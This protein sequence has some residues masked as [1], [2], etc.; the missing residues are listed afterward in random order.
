MRY[1]ERYYADANLKFAM[2]PG[3]SF[4]DYIGMQVMVPVSATTGYDRVWV[5]AVQADPAGDVIT[6]LVGSP[7][8]GIYL[9]Y[10]QQVLS[11]SMTEN[12]TL[13]LYA[14]KDGELFVGQSVSDYTASGRNDIVKT[15]VDMVNYGAAVQITFNHNA[16]SLPNTNLG[17]YAD[18]GTTTTPVFEATNSKTG[19]GSVAVMK[20]SISMQAKV[21]IQLMFKTSDMNGKTFSATVNGAEA[22]VEY[23]PYSSYTICRVAVGA[24]QMR[25]TFTIAL[26]DAN[27][28]PVTQVYE[29]SV[30][31]YGKA[32]LTT[33]YRDVIIAMMRYGDSVA[34]YAAG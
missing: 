17:V 6:E 10:D 8:Y 11:W 27:S 7:Y 20:D 15:L 19:T 25:D 12:V 29:V 1:T 4:Q 24:S 18:K 32:Q 9:V 26:Y 22:P 34:A 13:T 21:E 28:N 3:L 5:E 30:E 16:S 2:A 23:T 33:A 14:E 31:A